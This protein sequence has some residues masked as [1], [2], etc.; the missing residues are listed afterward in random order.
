[1]S[2]REW[3][4]VTYGQ[5]TKR[6]LLSSRVAIRSVV[7]G[8]SKHDESVGP[9]LCRSLDA[10]NS[11]IVARCRSSRLSV[12]AFLLAMRMSFTETSSR[13]LI[14]PH[15]PVLEFVQPKGG[16]T[17]QAEPLLSLAA[18]VAGERATDG[19]L[20][21]IVHGL[22][23]QPAVALARIWLLSPG[24]L[25]DTCFRK[26]DCDNHV[27]C[28]HLVASAGAPQN[29]AGED[30]SYLQGQFRRIPLGHR[31]V[32]EI[33]TTGRSILIPDSAAESEWIGRK[34]WAEREGIRAFAGYPLVARGEIL[35]VLAVFSR[36][37]LCQQE[38]VWLRIFADQVAVAITN[39]RAFEK[40]QQSEKALIERERQLQQ[41]VDIVPQHMVLLETDFSNSYGNQTAREYFGQVEQTSPTDFVNQTTHPEDA[42]RLLAWLLHT[43]SGDK[44]GETEVRIRKRDGLYRWFLHQLTPLRDDRGTVT[45][46][47]LTRVDIDDRKQA[48]ELAQRENLALREEIDK[49]SMFESIVGTS[50]A[51]QAVLARVAKVARTDSTVLITGETGTGKELVARAIHKRSLRSDRPFVSVNCAAIPRDLIASE[52]FGH[53]KGA[54]T[55]ALQRRLGRF[56][57]AEGGSIFLDEIGELPAET[58]VALLRV[59][60]EREFQRVGSNLSLR[61]D[62]RVIAATH[63]DLPEAIEAGAFRRDLYYRI[64][65]FPLEIPPLR[66]RREDI[67]LLVEYFIDRYASKTGK[68]IRHIA[69][70]SMDQLQSYAWPGN[71]R[72]LQNVIERSVILCDTENFSVDES[73]LSPEPRSSRVLAHEIIAQE[74]EFIESAL[75]ECKGRVSGP[76]GAAVRLGMPPSTL[77]SKIRALKIDKQRFHSA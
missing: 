69:R 23:A 12:S 34:E 76:S 6:K 44:P 29:S 63:R 17:V 68:H 25:C 5:V 75:A 53:E 56:E 71:I 28:L 52:L 1:M 2:D 15:V 74:K 49:V 55:G 50:P 45:R 9:A 41:I 36:E 39:A 61:A 48:A 43:I 24:D 35:G 13:L 60:Q 7:A 42:E 72:E 10:S 66:E 32:G 64:N 21:S 22:A 73:W 14:C 27:Q 30:W 31:K 67:R 38:F 47:C 65:V 62:V 26:A 16:Q 33:G 40:I 54:F 58:Q 59:L 4:P 70:R 19:V 18:A 11:S 8:A 37:A 20:N 46:W 51:L 3:I 57:L 77:D